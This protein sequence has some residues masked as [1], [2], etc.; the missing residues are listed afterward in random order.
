M[1]GNWL[2]ADRHPPLCRTQPIH[3]QLNFNTPVQ[4]FTRAFALDKEFL[5][6][7]ATLNPES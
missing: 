4:M 1:G 7:D 3:L 6:G 5:F 2:A